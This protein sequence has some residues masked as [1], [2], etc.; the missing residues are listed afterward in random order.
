MAS[1]RERIEHPQIIT[2]PPDKRCRPGARHLMPMF[3]LV[4]EDGLWLEDARLN[5]LE[6]KPGDRILDG[7]DSLEVVEVRAARKRRCWLSVRD[8]AARASSGQPRR[9]AG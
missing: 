5:T 2:S 7:R 3:K 9:R 6:W 8:M 4:T 1:R